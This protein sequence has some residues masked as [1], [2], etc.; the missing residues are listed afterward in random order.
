MFFSPYLKK[1]DLFAGLN[2][3]EVE[4][5]STIF[6]KET[7]PEGTIL[8]KEDTTGDD[9]YIVLHGKVGI[10]IKGDEEK[11]TLQIA[12]AEQYQL[13]GEFVLVDESP[14]SA[15]AI[16]AEDSTLLISSKEKFYT[17]AKFHRGIGFIIIK[18]LANLLCKRLRDTNIRWRNSVLYFSQPSSETPF[19]NSKPPKNFR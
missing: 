6:K 9:F 13:V 14:R 4:S 15:S 16:C 2:D 17:F 1:T 19:S 12:T 3:E 8:F 10:H 18:N 7:H 11:E 5:L